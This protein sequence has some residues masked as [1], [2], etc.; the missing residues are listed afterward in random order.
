MVSAPV[1][2]LL[3]DRTF[4]SL[5]FREAWR[6]HGRLF[7]ALA[8][9]WIPLGVLFL[10]S[11][12]NRGGSVGFGLGIR[13]WDYALTQF[14]AITTYL[15]LSLWPHPLVFDYGAAWVRGASLVAGDIALVVALVLA[16]AVALWR[17]PVLGFLGAWFFCILA[18][19]SLIPG[20]SQMIVEH[21]MYL[22]L[23]AVLALA[24]GV[25]SACLGGSSRTWTNLR[26]G[27]VERGG[28]HGRR[29]R[30]GVWLGQPDR[31]PQRG[32][33]HAGRAL[34]RQPGQA[35]GFPA[36]ICEPRHRPPVG[37]PGRGG[38]GAPT[39]GNPPGPDRHRGD[40]ERGQ[41]VCDPG[42]P[43]RG[44]RRLR[45]GPAVEARLRGRPR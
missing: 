29:R 12:G 25:A 35:A 8:A 37:R 31:P 28:V 26:P 16:T 13:W 9:T 43:A 20:T 10:L 1:L 34:A 14:P 45:M 19:T 24:V 11:G 33:P 36:R 38:P 39:G 21:R 7:L 22:P 18:P 32:L 42:P 30:L 44:R 15:R 23:A 27:G 3:Y 5:G 41:C 17:R 2:V 4:V 6:R 40:Q